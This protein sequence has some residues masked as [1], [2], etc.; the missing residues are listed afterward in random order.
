M[1]GYFVHH[2]VAANILMIAACSLGL[3]V[4]SGM[5]R[6]SFPEFAAS[7]SSTPALLP[8]TWTNRSVPKLT[9]R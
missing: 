7:R 8:W 9:A 3:S 2:P 4:I 1:I 6:E 5:E